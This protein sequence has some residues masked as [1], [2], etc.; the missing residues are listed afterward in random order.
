MGTAQQYINEKYEITAWL[1]GDDPL[2]DETLVGVRVDPK[3]MRA[4]TEGLISHSYLEVSRE[5]VAEDGEDESAEL[6]LGAVLE[7]PEGTEA[8]RM[9]SN[10]V[11]GY[12]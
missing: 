7:D 12:F 10:T 8:E 6:R 11:H 4:D 2:F 1:T 3:N 5:L 9:T